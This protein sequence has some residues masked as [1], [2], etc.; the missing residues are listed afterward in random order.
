MAAIDVDLVPIVESLAITVSWRGNPVFIRHR[1]PAEI[2]AAKAVKP[3]DLKDYTARNENI[4]DNAPATDENRVGGG[5]EQF[6][7]MLGVC[8]HLGCAP[9]S[10][11]GSYA[12]L[13]GNAKTGN[14]FCPCHGSHYDT[15][16]H[17]REGPAP[18]NLLVMKH[19]PSPVPSC[20]FA[21][22]RLA[23]LGSHLRKRSIQ[24]LNI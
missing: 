3:K 23:R 10:N 15:A 1:A 11:E 19:A 7:I 13:E 24:A 20:E 8:T 5:K 4:K 12:A 6:L 9:I 17:I 14:W 18:V 2:E 16:G 22:S 21:S